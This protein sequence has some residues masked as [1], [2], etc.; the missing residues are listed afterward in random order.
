MFF[1]I[2]AGTAKDKQQKNDSAHR[3]RLK[4]QTGAAK[5]H[6]EEAKDL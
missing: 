1:K 4:G 5:E 6:G 3:K 2:P